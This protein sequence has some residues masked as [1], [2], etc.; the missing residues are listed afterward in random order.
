MDMVLGEEIPTR[1]L[2]ALS[3][4]VI[5]ASAEYPNS[6]PI[7]LRELAPPVLVAFMPNAGP[8]PL[9]DSIVIVYFP[10]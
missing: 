6:E 10:L 1:F 5:C 4:K 2:N 9:K 3:F 8:E 7:W